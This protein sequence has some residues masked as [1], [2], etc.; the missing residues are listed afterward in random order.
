MI[1]DRARIKILATLDGKDHDTIVM[2]LEN[3]TGLRLELAKDQAKSESDLNTGLL[4]LMA[5]VTGDNDDLDI[6]YELELNTIQEGLLTRIRASELDDGIENSYNHFNNK[7]RTLRLKHEHK[8]ELNVNRSIQGA[9]TL[10][11]EHKQRLATLKHKY[12]QE[13]DDLLVSISIQGAGL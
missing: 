3:L 13:V 12:K 7:V 9:E 6:D 5:V 1:N 11:I 4:K 8:K 10:R 2:L